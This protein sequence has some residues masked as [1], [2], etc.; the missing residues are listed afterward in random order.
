MQSVKINGDQAGQ[1]LDRFLKKHLPGAESGF[2]YKMLRKKNITLNGSRAA[3]SEILREGD[4]V[5]FFFSEE[6]YGKFTAPDRGGI[7]LSEYERAYEGLGGI[8]TV[9]EDEDILILNKPAGILSQKAGEQDLSLNEWMIG[10]LLHG[11]PEFAARLS[12][13][14]P[15]VCNR[16]DR[17]TS[18]LVLCGK[19]PAGLRLLSRFVRERAVR[20]YYRTICLGSF[21][22]PV[23]AA[24]YLKK[25]VAKNK[26]FVTPISAAG[27]GV[28]SHHAEKNAG[29][30]TGNSAGNSTGNSAAT[31]LENGA[32]IETRY[33]PV[34]E[35]GGYTLL[36][37]ELITG[38]PHQIRGQLAQMGHPVAGDGKY[39]NPQANRE[40]K[41]RFGLEYQLLHAFQVDF[42]ETQDPAGR[43][44]SGKSFTA[45]YPEQF[46]RIMR[47]LHLKEN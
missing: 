22:E 21:R 8:Q 39:G 28:S 34:C 33:R 10:Y 44:V 5:C 47:E 27:N 37:V 20:K 42:S 24:G 15:S 46:L 38:K 43:S 14:R 3:G 9:H 45:E 11:N 35:K 29:N 7:R 4:Q 23:L 6:T 41:E 36:E 13:F 31:N 17:N 30:S 32:Y 19:S 18:G 2:L 12:D 25:D 26:V 40:L 1:R 16:L